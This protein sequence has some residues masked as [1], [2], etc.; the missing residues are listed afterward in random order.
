MDLET[1]DDWCP[2][3]VENCASGLCLSKNLSAQVAYTASSLASELRVE[4]EC[5]F[6]LPVSS[7]LDYF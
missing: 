3:G 4:E 2:G 5:L 1:V 7:L 6:L